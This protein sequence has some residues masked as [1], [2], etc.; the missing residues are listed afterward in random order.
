MT[1]EKRF[2][3]LE[4]LF[5]SLF[6]YYKT[7]VL[8]DV[9]DKIKNVNQQ[10]C[11][12]IKFEHEFW[13]KKRKKQKVIKYSLISALF[14][15][16]IGFFLIMLNS[17]EPCLNFD[18]M[19]CKWDE[20]KKSTKERL[21]NKKVEFNGNFVELR[22]ITR[23]YPEILTFLTDAEIKNIEGIVINP[24]DLTLPFKYY[25]RKITG[26]D[27]DYYFFGGNCSYKYFPG[28]TYD[29]KT[30][31]SK[32][33]SRKIYHISDEP[34]AGKSTLFIERTRQKR[35]E[36]SDIWVD[37]L[38]LEKF[39]FINYTSL[40][41][42]TSTNL[43]NFLI[44]VHNAGREDLQKI[45]LNTFECEMF[46]KNLASGDVA[47]FID[48]IDNIFMDNDK[49]A[50]NFLNVLFEMSNNK[51]ELWI[52][53]RNW[54]GGRIEK[55]IQNYDKDFGGRLKL[56]PLHC[57]DRDE[58]LIKTY[59]ERHLT[60]SEVDL[61]RNRINE[62]FKLTDKWRNWKKT[63]V[64]NICL[65]KIM[66]NHTI[67]SVRENEINVNFYDILRDYMNEMKAH[68]KGPEAYSEAA[69]PTLI[70][71][72]LR[73]VELNYN[74]SLKA[75]NLTKLI[76]DQIHSINY[77]TNGNF[78]VYGQNG[79]S[80]DLTNSKI[81]HEVERGV[82]KVDI[83]Q[84]I[85]FL[86]LINFEYYVANYIRNKMWHRNFWRPQD[87]IFDDKLLLLFNI[88][89]DLNTEFPIVQ[90]CIVDAVNVIQGNE[91]YKRNYDEMFK[92]KFTRLYDDFI[93]GTNAHVGLDLVKVFDDDEEMKEIIRKSGII[94]QEN[95]K[96]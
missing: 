95:Y 1:D 76:D 44:D 65:L 83:N 27:E 22:N 14:L 84:N 15:A 28:N 58:F 12:N 68:K 71:V 75:V 56:L 54:F 74:S 4:L 62:V 70:S 5:H 81:L 78:T 31:E 3:T 40:T 94:Q 48:H 67:E 8:E 7:Y 73:Y 29:L 45:K 60:S 53:S 80:W 79:S 32:L 46:K 2:K 30:Y 88:F 82:L 35:S 96:R 38:D 39:N 21:L 6:D 41:N 93:N 37:Y 64:D 11:E 43:T 57:E 26:Y 9:R 92:M 36:T 77:D 20:L 34:V 42:W 18:N 13:E 51:S 63:Y 33:K 91:A 24:Q 19:T 17:F 59:N 49:F 90:R 86:H 66:I 50:E 52:A 89:K 87:P 47:L 72:A 55:I 25:A 61:V 69:D 16:M 10:F 23:E 85:S